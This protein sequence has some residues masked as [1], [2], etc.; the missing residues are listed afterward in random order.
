MI[1][2]AQSSILWIRVKSTLPEQLTGMVRL[3][4]ISMSWISLIEIFRETDL[5]ELDQML[6]PT[7][8]VAS[9]SETSKQEIFPTLFL[10]IS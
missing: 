9:S 5:M 6:D 7:S 4:M 3:Q 2:I 8:A 1:L 10:T